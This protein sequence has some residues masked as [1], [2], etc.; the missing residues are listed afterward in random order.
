MG[1]NPKATNLL[2]NRSFISKRPQEIVAFTVICEGAGHATG[3]G[4]PSSRNGKM[5]DA[6]G[7]EYFLSVGNLFVTLHVIMDT[8]EAM[9]EI[10]LRIG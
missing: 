8:V 6:H 7:A 1:V 10:E 4:G 2:P 9:Q 3:V 5:Q